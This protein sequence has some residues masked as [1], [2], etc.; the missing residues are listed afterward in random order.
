MTPFQRRQLAQSAAAVVGVDAGKFTH[1]LVVRVRDEADSKPLT[2]ETRRA[3]FDRAAAFIREAARDAAPSEILVG[4]EFAGTYG[5]TLAHYLHALGL[6]VVSVLPA[7]TKHWQEVTHNQRLKTDAKDAAVIADLVAQ[8]Q[9][10]SFP[11]LATPYADLRYLTSAREGVT[12]L[13]NAAIT[14]LKALLDVVFPEYERIF[15]NFE[16]KTALAL[17]DA[18][19][20]PAALLTAPRRRLMRVLTT[21]SRNHLGVARYEELMHAARESIGLPSAQGALKD[22]L[23]LVLERIRLYNAQLATLKG[24]MLAVL[25]TVPEAEFLLTIPRVAPVTAATFLGSI[26]DPQAYES[27][28]QILKLAGLSLV[29]RSS[30]LTKGQRR[31][32]K[33]GRPVLR[34]HAFMLA[35]RS[36]RGDGMFRTDYERLLRNNGGVKLAAITAIS[37]K[38]LKLMFRVARERRPFVPTLPIAGSSGVADTEHS[39]SRLVRERMAA[40]RR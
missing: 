6:P 18:Y 5:F 35:L 39:E 3:G 10:V 26:G 38:M 25:H 21:T 29:E 17:L 20:G 32:S 30:G 28:A 24:R 40:A 27:S 11:F 22:E 33:R 8:G 13:K 15:V 36:V 23:P 2:I 19:P 1:T 16:G 31:I 34:R 9:F 37:R 7:H 12:V 14:R 4:I